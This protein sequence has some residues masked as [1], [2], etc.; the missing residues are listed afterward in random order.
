MPSG[1]LL[2]ACGLLSMLMP[3][4]K[5]LNNVLND[6]QLHLISVMRRSCSCSAPSVFLTHG[7]SFVKVRGVATEQS[8]LLLHL[9]HSV[10]PR[11]GGLNMHGV[12]ASKAKALMACPCLRS[13]ACYAGRWRL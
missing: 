1:I 12:H 3:C 7:L 9:L 4:I 13:Q 6:P 11:S 2:H 10:L 8:V 5:I